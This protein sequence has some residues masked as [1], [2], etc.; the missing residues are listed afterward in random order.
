VIRNQ[1]TAI[2]SWYANHGAYLKMVPRRY[3]RRY[4]SFDEWMEYCTAFFH[5]SPLESF[6]YYQALN[7]YK[8][9]FGK[10]RIK[11]LL[12][13]DFTGNKTAFNNA[14]AGILNLNPD[15]VSKFLEGRHERPR[16]TTRKIK[17]DRFRST[18]FHNT[19]LSKFLPFGNTVKQALDNFLASGKPAQIHISDHWKNV[20]RGLYQ[21][22][23]KKLAEEYSLPLADYGYP[24]KRPQG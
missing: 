17:Y 5:Y 24:I 8:D 4:V 13:E 15:T 18:F 14:L 22:D 23:N 19:S 1:L 20:L 9:L 12:F 11:I 16:N 7:L 2:P 6:L 3:W 10:D 21:E